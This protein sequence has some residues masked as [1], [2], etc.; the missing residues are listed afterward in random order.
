MEQS[1]VD[2]LQFKEM[3]EKKAKDAQ[4]EFGIEELMPAPIAL[5]QFDLAQ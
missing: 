5:V 3:E 2:N 1:N 4:E